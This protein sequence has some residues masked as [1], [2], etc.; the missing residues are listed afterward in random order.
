MGGW[1]GGWVGGGW[2]GGWN[3]KVGGMEIWVDVEV[4]GWVGGW[5]GYLLPSFACPQHHH[6]SNARM[7]RGARPVLL[8]LCCRRPGC[9][10]LL[11]L[12]V[13]SR[14]SLSSSSSSSQHQIIHERLPSPA[15]IQARPGHQACRAHWPSSSF[16]SSSISIPIVV[17]VVGV[18]VIHPFFHTTSVVEKNPKFLLSSAARFPPPASPARGCQ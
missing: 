3:E 9:Y 16:S 1:V 15:L 4:G 6:L 2:K 5:V 17:V 14:P 18:G 7:G 8:L 10:L 12:H 13:P 11:L